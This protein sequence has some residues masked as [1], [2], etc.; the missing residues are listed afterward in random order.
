MSER[1]QTWP[2][3]AKNLELKMRHLESRL[4]QKIA[5]I[6][7][8]NDGLRLQVQD[9]EDSLEMLWSIWIAPQ[10]QVLK[11]IKVAK[12]KEEVLRT[13]E[14]I[15]QDAVEHALNVLNGNK[16]SAARSL[17]IDIS[18]LYAMLRRWSNAEDN[19]RRRINDNNG[20]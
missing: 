19:N 3:R 14:E 18:T 9:L 2:E 4:N 13:M 6:A 7:E 5:E 15:K 16:T 17:N 20:R 8:D 11:Q 12:S 1:K 10:W